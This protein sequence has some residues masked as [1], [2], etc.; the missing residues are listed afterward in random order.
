M[1]LMGRNSY[2][3]LF[4]VK[5]A[6]LPCS[7]CT[8]SRKKHLLL[9]LWVMS[10]CVWAWCVPWSHSTIRVLASCLTWCASWFCCWRN[11]RRDYIV[12]QTVIICY[13]TKTR[14]PTQ[15]RIQMHSCCSVCFVIPKA[16]SP[17]MW[18]SIHVQLWH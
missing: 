15:Y 12:R 5:L 3:L 16:E 17:Y 18:V 7:S 1:W 4:M 8:R 2:Q 11:G 10:V 6:S 14:F 9:T 13:T